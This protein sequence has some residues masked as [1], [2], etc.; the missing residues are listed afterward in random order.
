MVSPIFTTIPAFSHGKNVAIPGENLTSKS[1]EMPW[2][3]GDPSRCPEDVP[4]FLLGEKHLMRW[5]SKS[6]QSDYSAL[7]Q[8]DD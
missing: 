7:K 8:S 5:M 1:S 6:D 3:A 2:Y 4:P